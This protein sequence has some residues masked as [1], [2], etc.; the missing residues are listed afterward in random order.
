MKFHHCQGKNHFLAEDGQSKSYACQMSGKKFL[1]SRLASKF[2]LWTCTSSDTRIC[3]LIICFWHS[4]PAILQEQN[5]IQILQQRNR[6]MRHWQAC[7]NILQIS[8]QFTHLNSYSSITYW[9]RHVSSAYTFTHNTSTRWPLLKWR[10]HQLFVGQWILLR[11][12]S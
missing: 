12:T 8:I 3:F 10:L 1:N 9:E 7:Q 6:R 5:I 11:L 4:L 2:K